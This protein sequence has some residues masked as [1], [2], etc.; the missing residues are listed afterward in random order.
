MKSKGNFTFYKK[1]NK[2]PEKTQK[3][4]NNSKII[5]ENS[6]LTTLREK[7]LIGKNNNKSSIYQIKNRKIDL[8]KLNKD[9]DINDKKVI[10]E[11]K[12]FKKIIYI[13]NK[14]KVKQVNNINKIKKDN[15]LF[16]KIYGKIKKDKIKF[17]TGTYLDYEPFINISIKY[18]SRNMKIPN[19]SEEHNIFSGNP[20]ILE[21]TQLEDYFIYNYGNKDKAIKYLNKIDA[22]IDKKKLGNFP[23]NSQEMENLH[24]I[25]ENEMPKGYV[26]PQIEIDRLKNDINDTQK[27]FKDLPEFETFFE[28][29]KKRKI[30]N[31]IS[32]NKLKNRSSGN[33]FKKYNN[34]NSNFINVNNKLDNIK[35]NSIT[36]Y[37]T[38]YKNNWNNNH[39]SNFK[40]LILNYNS[41][42]P[43]RNSVNSLGKIS[44][45]ESF[46]EFN[47]NSYENSYSSKQQKTQKLKLS[48]ISSPF[49]S[50]SN[51][52][53]LKKFKNIDANIDKN[54]Y[55]KIIFKNK[56][57]L[58][59]QKRFFSE[60]K[61]PKNKLRNLNEMIYYSIIN[62][63]KKRNMSTLNE[64]NANLTNYNEKEKSYKIN[65]ER[66]NIKNESYHK[67]IG[68]IETNINS[69]S[70]NIKKIKKISINNSI[71]E[72]KLSNKDK[73][74]IFNEKDS[75]EEK[76]K[77][78]EKLYNT[79]RINSK[80]SNKKIENYALSK[81]KDLNELI[82]KKDIYYSFYRLKKKATSRNLILEEYNMRKENINR[83][84]LFSKEKV[85]LEKNKSFVNGVINLEKK[86]KK[87]IVGVNPNE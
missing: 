23:I 59:P 6:P 79:T 24:K 57:H 47:F 67:N 35:Y 53:Q 10:S 37:C 87:M 75:K 15:K 86:L 12:D 63:N 16:S 56:F 2:T 40:K 80:E 58:S 45:F 64:D 7:S 14:D 36:L 61:F 29:L 9:N 76:Y 3:S 72:N 11:I 49:I 32:L 21:G 43:S 73:E 54:N 13:H 69:Y 50:S 38:K 20:L 65:K 84:S 85:N 31:K 28:K 41:T 30:I 26:P 52:I 4:I 5:L 42:R 44:N 83:E 17:H 8:M 48:P 70:N 19:L 60:I 71:Y 82:N 78:I 27:S 39:N 33:I 62:Y 46:R 74:K 77:I 81:G 55:L 1:I 51:N 22:I 68:N 25:E 66:E 18:L 34:L